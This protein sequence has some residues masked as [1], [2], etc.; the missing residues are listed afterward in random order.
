MYVFK[1]DI[2]KT[3]RKI[4]MSNIKIE[5]VEAYFCIVQTEPYK[6][7]GLAHQAQVGPS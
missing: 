3:I 2:R 7:Y 5:K 1:Q 6:V 4:I